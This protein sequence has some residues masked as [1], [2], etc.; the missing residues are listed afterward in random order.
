M[1]VPEEHRREAR[2]AEGRLGFGLVTV[3]DSREREDDVSGDRM[4]ARVEEAGHRVEERLL[5]PDETAPLR[6][7]VTALLA[8]DEVDV[9]VVS[10]GTGISP[11]DVTVEALAPLFERDL[12]GFGELFRMLSFREIG[13]A[14]LLS[15]ATAGVSH[16][17][18]VFLLP[19]SPA[20]VELALRELILPE[21]AHVVA[22]ARRPGRRE[23]GGG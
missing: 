7:A 9:V 17:R 3:S 10:G 18:A 8:Q 4:A 11:R 14:A 5:L 22:Q 23:P 21:A 2:Q 15:R 6:N 19:G 16:G 13:A 20:A 1:N 12:P